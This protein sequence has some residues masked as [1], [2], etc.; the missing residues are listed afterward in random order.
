MKLEK[1]SIKNLRHVRLFFPFESGPETGPA[2]EPRLRALLNYSKLIRELLRRS[3]KVLYRLFTEA[4][5]FGSGAGPVSGPDSNG[6]KSRTWR[7]FDRFWDKEGESDIH[8]L[9]KCSLVIQEAAKSLASGRL[10]FQK[11]RATNINQ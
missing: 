1:L 3:I 4:R 6:K 2:P 8:S 9:V 11:H 10:L 7:K 5:S